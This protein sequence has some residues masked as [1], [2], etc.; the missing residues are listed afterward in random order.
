[1]NNA[2]PSVMDYER[3]KKFFRAPSGCGSWV[4]AGVLVLFGL[5]SLRNDAWGLGILL[6]LG[7]GLIVFLKIKSSRNKP[8]VAEIDEVAASFSKNVE[9]EAL[10]KLM[11]DKDQLVAST[12][13]FWSYALG[14]AQFVDPALTSDKASDSTVAAVLQDVVSGTPLIFRLFFP[15]RAITDKHC[16]E[17][18][19]TRSC[20]VSVTA[21]LFTE[22]A[23]HYYRKH[24]SMISDANKVETDEL[25]Y[26]HVSSVNTEEEDYSYKVQGKSIRTRR[27]IL[28]LKSDG[29]KFLFFA[30]TIQESESAAKSIKTMLREK[31][32]A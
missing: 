23:I 2:T 24:N 5:L 25:F 29:E 20:H 13:A 12:V 28:G 6:L 32:S 26:K 31:A 7:A 10:K 19:T 11:L 1:M 8:T 22:D 21:F 14:P 9:S 30:R 4:I 15:K 3:N 17:D 16:D 27:N 18:N